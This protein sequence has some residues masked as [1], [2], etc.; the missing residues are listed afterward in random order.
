MGDLA[1][2]TRRNGSRKFLGNIRNRLHHKTKMMQNPVA[3]EQETARSASTE[4]ARPASFAS[5]SFA[6]V[7]T[8]AK[9]SAPQP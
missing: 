1:I 9:I 8:P 4:L 5:R 3:A 7:I 6:P 2:P